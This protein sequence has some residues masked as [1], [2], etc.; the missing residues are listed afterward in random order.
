MMGIVLLTGATGFVGH[1]ILNSLAARGVRVRVLVRDGKQARLATQPC[2]ESVV[3]TT[4]LFAET[5]QWWADVCDG[6]DTVIHAAWYAEPGKYLQSEKNLD[7]LAGTLQLAKGAAAAGVRRFLGIG[8]CFEYDLTSGVLSVQTPLRPLTPYAGAKVAV[9]MAL[10]QWFAQ[11][12]IEFV[13]CRLF[14]LYGE[15]EDARRLVPYLRAQLSAGEPAE[16]T[17]GTQIRDFLNVQ[18]A[19][20]MICDIALSEKQ[21]AANICSGMPVTVRQLAERIAD[22]YGRR[23]LLRFGSRPENLV[24][25]PRVVGVP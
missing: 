1:Q 5:S 16:L 11:E 3:V 24:D 6:V 25:P 9:F 8:T 12:R 14:Y 23:D 17:S 10:S 22:E 7:C 4:D 15:G 19:G 2:V 21:G 20:R 18:E 13:W